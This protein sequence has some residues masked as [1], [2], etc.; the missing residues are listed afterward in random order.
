M[1][2]EYRK[3]IA[4]WQKAR[5]SGTAVV[6]EVYRFYFFKYWNIRN[7]NSMIFIWMAFMLIFMLLITINC[8]IIIQ[9]Y[10]VVS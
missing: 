9:N 4:V 3:F 2:P 1:D 10:L 7:S 6:N 8:G 5:D